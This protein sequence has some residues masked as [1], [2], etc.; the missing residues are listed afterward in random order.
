[1]ESAALT[2]PT[3]RS[4]RVAG[5]VLAAGAGRRYGGP[6]ALVRLDGRLLV[7]RVVRVARDGGCDPVVPVL[8]AAATT[9]RQQAELDDAVPVENPDWPTGMG[10][11][12]RAGLAALSGTDAVAA[13]VLL[14][15]MPGVT[16]E[17][18]RRLADLA[19]PTALAMAGYGDRRG[20][21]VLLG[22]DHWTGVTASAVG[23]I[24]ARAYL[25]ERA[26]QL[27]VVP[28][29]DVADDTDLDVPPAP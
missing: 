3:R 11:S 22:R 20:H 23:D 6:K 21:P 25:R 13:I 19:G 7:E 18:V 29:A 15:D 17:A 12:L 27:R 14:V 1:M 10:S 26:T 24:G 9:V 2:P 5:L 28:C 4:L 8:G 16:A